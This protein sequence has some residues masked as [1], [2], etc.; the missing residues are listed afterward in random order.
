M[1]SIWSNYIKNFNVVE[2]PNHKKLI[3]E[4]LDRDSKNYIA[5]EKISDCAIHLPRMKSS[6]DKKYNLAHDLAII[7]FS[8]ADNDTNSS[9]YIY[10][11][12][13]CYMK[14]QRLISKLSKY[15]KNQVRE[16]ENWKKNIKSIMKSN[17]RQ[18]FCVLKKRPVS[19]LIKNPTPMPVVES[20]YE[21][22]KPFFDHLASNI[23]VSEKEGKVKFLRGIQYSDNRMDLC[24]MVVGPNNICKLTESLKNNEHIKHFL[25]GNNIINLEGAKAVS[26]FIKNQNFNKCKI[27]TWY[28][29]GNELNSESIKLIAEELKND[30]YCESLWLKR[31]PIGV[32]GSKYLGEMLKEN[33]HIKILDLHN[34][35]LF[36]EGIKNIFENLQSNSSLRKIYL[37]A[38]GITSKGI[39]Y[40]ANY[41]NY[42]VQHNKKGLTSIWLDINR[43]GDDG[44]VKLANCL[45]KYKHL[46]RIYLGSN[47]IEEDGIKHLVDA[48]IH[49]PE[50]IVFDVSIYKSTS[51]LSE[52][53]NNF[54]DN[55]CEYILKLIQENKKIQILNIMYNNISLDYLWK[56]AEALEN[57][58]NIL[59]LQYFQ[60][61]EPVPKELS[62]KIKNKLEQNIFNQLNMNYNHFVNTELR[63][64]RASKKLKFIDSD[65]RNKM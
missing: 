24:K 33:K 15:Y 54:S 59:F 61:K 28:L 27:Q 23:S 10:K 57:N 34:T 8:I 47:R 52:L 19:D 6:L 25:L 51:D 18:N 21:E 7:L 48:F 1:T 62:E 29:A 43:I 14:Y 41:F 12:K 37:D 2:W 3:I 38:N 58:N 31:N 64:L 26:N 11:K 44:A 16:E 17:E 22:L 45:K 56:I 42:L 13:W 55:G 20:P 60:N 9:N 40:I 36:D 49:H 35:G 50:L 63:F 32:I 65:Y 5:G 30:I 53:P 39:D 4:Q 46:K